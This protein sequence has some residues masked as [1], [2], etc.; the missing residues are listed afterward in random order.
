M[1]EKEGE[2]ERRKREKEGEEERRKREK[3]EQHVHTSMMHPSTS[4]Q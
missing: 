2:E 3:R 1:A 4:M